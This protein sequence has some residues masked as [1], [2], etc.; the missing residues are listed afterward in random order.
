MVQLEEYLSGDPIYCEGCDTEFVVTST[1][2]PEQ[3]IV[4]CP[5]CGYNIDE[6]FAEEDYDDIIDEDD[7]DED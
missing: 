7:E 5:F 6:G 2:Y 4:F 3:E 1:D